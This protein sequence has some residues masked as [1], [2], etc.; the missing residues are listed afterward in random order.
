MEKIVIISCTSRSGSNTM[1][2][3]RIYAG[4]LKSKNI[5]TEILDLSLLPSNFIKEDL[6]GNRSEN[7]AATITRFIAPVTR[8]I[9]VVPEYNGSFPGVLKVFLDAIPPKEWTNKYVCLV[10]VS[11]GRAGNLRG[12]EHL[13]GILNYLKMHVYHNKLPI[14]VVDK[15]LDTE[16]NFNNDAQLKTSYSQVE[17]FLE[18]T[19][20]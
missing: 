18:W 11:V 4:I 17:G 5:E 9:F 20:P 2:V 16:E 15:L 7:F 10:G 3:S 1:K 14:S 6:H 19:S 13:T 12:M 8:F